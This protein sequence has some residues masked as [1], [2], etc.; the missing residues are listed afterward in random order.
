MTEWQSSLIGQPP[1]TDAREALYTTQRDADGYV[2]NYLRLWTWRPDV[3]E[4]FVALR[5]LVTDES[6]LSPSECAVIVTAT[7]SEL[8]DS[9]CSLAW[10]QKLAKLHDDDTAA[11]ILTH[12]AAPTLS[13]R[14]A[15]LEAWARQ[16]VRDPNGTSAADVARLR[17]AGF[18]EREIFEATTF[19]ALRL[20]FSTV[21]D[22]LGATPDRQLA[23]AAPDVIRAAVDYG[24]APSADPT[25]A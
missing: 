14:E 19:I 23:D 2:S 24:R 25:P 7:A 20:A 13:A 17:D 21:N 6:T 16:V 11:Q 12:A 4:S 1:E 3:Y 22:A 15:A 10:G 9:Y 18:D 8:G 5:A